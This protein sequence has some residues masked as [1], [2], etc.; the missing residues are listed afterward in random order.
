[1]GRADGDTITVLYD[2]IRCRVR[3]A[4]IDAAIAADLGICRESCHQL[5]ARALSV[6]RRELERVGVTGLL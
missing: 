1:V 2:T 3:R 6:L 5:K 4:G